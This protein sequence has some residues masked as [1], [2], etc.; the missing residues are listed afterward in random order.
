MVC[1]PA[2]GG[3]TFIALQNFGSTNY[4]CTWDGSTPSITG[5]INWQFPVYAGAG[6]Q[7]SAPSWAP[8]GA[9]K[10]V[11]AATVAMAAEAIQRGVP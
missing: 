8:N 10:C 2:P 6:T 7:W 9:I 5:T 11:A 4:Y 1:G 3:R